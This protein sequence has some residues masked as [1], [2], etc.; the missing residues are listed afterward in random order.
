MPNVFSLVK[1]L[2]CRQ[3]SSN[4]K[5][6]CYNRWNTQFSTVLLKYARPS[7]KKTLSGWKHTVCCSKTGY[8]FQHWWCLS[9]CASCPSIGT[10]APQWHQRWKLLNWVLIT[11]QMVPLFFSLE[12]A[13]SMVSKKSLKF[14]FVWPQKQFF[15]FASV[16]FK[17]LA[18]RRWRRFWIMFRYDYFFS[19]WSCELCS[20]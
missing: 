11:R 15:H 8:T 4:T 10:N 14:R 1:C 9:R 3:D 18:Q 20:R 16:H 13:A 12:D 19:W 7:L 6:W 5:P 17:A 2:D